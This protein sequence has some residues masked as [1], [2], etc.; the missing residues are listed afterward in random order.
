MGRSFRR[1][2]PD[3]AAAGLR[4][5]GSFYHP[6]SDRHYV[7]EDRG[8]KLVQRRFQRDPA[9]R[10][11]NVLEKEI[12]FVMGSGNHARTFIHM[13]PSGKLV[14]LPLGWYSQDGG[15]WRMSPGY[16]RP[17]HDG[18]Q[19]VISYDCMF[20]HN[21]YPDV[22]SGS[23][24]PGRRPVFPGNIPDGIDC[25]RCHGPGSAH[26]EAAT[27]AETDTDAVASSITNPARLEVQR[28]REVCF[29][30]HLETTSRPLPNIVHRYGRGYFSYRAGEPLQDY[31]I[32]FDHA[33]GSG[34]EDKFE[35]NHSA[36]RLTQSRCFTQA[37]D[38]I[39]CTTCHD[40]HKP[41]GTPEAARRYDRE[42]L[43]CHEGGLAS[44]GSGGAHAWRSDCTD[45]HMPKRRTD[46]VVHAV[47]T[48]HRI[49]SKPPPGLLAPK[50]ERSSLAE[51]G[52]SGEVALHYPAALPDGRDDLYL[53]LAQTAQGSNLDAGI[54]RLESAIVRHRPPEAGF[55]FE[56]GVALEE[57]DRLR[58]AAR[59]FERAVSADPGFTLA[60]IRLGSALSRSGE[61]AEAELA[62]QQAAALDP[63]DARIPKEVGMDLARQ[64]L[65]Q[66]AAEASRSAISLDPDLPELHNNLGGA[67]AELG[68]VDEA[69]AALREA[70]RL[71][72]DLA[73]ARF[74]LGAVLAGR[75]EA[76]GAVRQWREAVQ[77]DPGYA[78]ARYNL[79]VL[80]ARDGNHDAAIEHLDAALQAE[81]GF[82][83]ARD[84][85][86][87]MAAAA[88]QTLVPS[89]RP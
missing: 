49:Q 26:V 64:G 36:Y 65:Y 20:C 27:R 59:W 85:R 17:N 79:A 78:M 69:E 74:N 6:A 48:D 70:V 25:Q 1:L 30:C 21:G 9:G 84:L 4:T 80:L 57:K 52:Y 18:F 14:Q 16:D 88:G 63:L 41:S 87:Q 22:P 45:C 32:Y 15:I 68:R 43:K 13:A 73:E 71:Q 46:D 37:A 47:M 60:W 56:L 50:R 54:A 23:D 3:S 31:A 44:L 12:H 7:V 34:W 77:S 8:G 19:R 29:Q 58:E 66:E 38:A 83:R 86:E 35:I 33:P 76:A 61:Y 53:A 11:E 39:T 55:Y 67:L 40:P 82:A 51:T 10:Q 62:L 89:L 42:C 81:P 24:R 5:G 2:G 75:G 72:P 28:Q